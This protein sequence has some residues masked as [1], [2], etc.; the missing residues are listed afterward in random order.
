M[1]TVVRKTDITVQSLKRKERHKN[2]REKTAIHW[3]NFLDIHTIKYI[4][5]GL[6]VI[7]MVYVITYSFI[8]IFCIVINN[9]PFILSIISLQSNTLEDKNLQTITSNSTENNSNVNESVVS[10]AK[11]YKDCTEA[12]INK[13]RTQNILIEYNYYEGYYLYPR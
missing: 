3:L 9:I 12:L 13:T 4:I 7:K 11:R 8:L 5:A 10:R 6:S 2:V 1:I